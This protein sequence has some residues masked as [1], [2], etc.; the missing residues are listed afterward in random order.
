MLDS[1]WSLRLPVI[2][3]WKWGS[4]THVRSV[5]MLQ[6]NTGS[7]DSKIIQG[8]KA[9]LFLR[10]VRGEDKLQTDALVVLPVNTY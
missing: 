3:I 5:L 7:V 6:K 9:R 1:F 10:E 8:E 2:L 4:S